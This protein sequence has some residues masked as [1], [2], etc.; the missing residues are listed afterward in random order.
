MTA[1]SEQNRVVWPR[2]ARLVDIAPAAKRP[3]SLAG[4]TIAFLW[5]YLFRGDEVF[6]ILEEG[7]KERFPGARFV[8][9]QTFGNTHGSDEHRVVAALPGRLQDHRVDAV[10]SGMGC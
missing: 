10:I 5:D 8:G 1:V 2:G 4:K 9:Y 7:L 3:Q 6:R